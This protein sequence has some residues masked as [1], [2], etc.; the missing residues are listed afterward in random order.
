M[1][2][3]TLRQDLHRPIKKECHGSC[4]TLHTAKAVGFLSGSPSVHFWQPSGQGT[5]SHMV[6]AIR[7]RYPHGWV[8]VTSTPDP[9]SSL[10]WFYP[11]GEMGSPLE[12][13]PMTYVGT[14]PLPAG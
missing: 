14:S 13:H 3:I 5:P 6:C 7:Q 12:P 2:T 4:L 1:S 10:S 8:P 9:F 11:V